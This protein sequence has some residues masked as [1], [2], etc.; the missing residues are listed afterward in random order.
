VQALLPEAIAA[1]RSAGLDATDLR[2]IETAK[3]QVENLGTGSGTFVL[4]EP[5]RENSQETWIGRRLSGAL[6]L[7]EHTSNGLDR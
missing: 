1:W 3:V 5:T 7:W 6:L 4:P 2:R